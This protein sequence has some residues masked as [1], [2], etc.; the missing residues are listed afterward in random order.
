MRDVVI[1]FDNLWGMS[2]PYVMPL[3]QSPTDGGDYRSFHFHIEFHPPL[4]KPHH[5]VPVLP[6]TA[7]FAVSVVAQV[8]LDAVALLSATFVPPVVGV[9]LGIGV[10][11]FGVLVGTVPPQPERLMKRLRQSPIFQCV[12]R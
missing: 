9:A 5:L 7:K 6:S 12:A 11:G 10:A 4:R 2:F 3:H 8:L 1:R